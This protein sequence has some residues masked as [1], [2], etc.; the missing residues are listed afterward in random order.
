MNPLTSQRGIL[1]VLL[2]TVWLLNACSVVPHRESLPGNAINPEKITHWQIIGKIA[3]RSPERNSS[4]RLRWKQQDG[5]FNIGLSGPLGR[6]VMNISGTQQEALIEITGQES[7]Y[8]TEPEQTLREQTG[9]DIPLNALL[10]W[11]RGGP[12][13]NQASH[14]QLDAVGRNINM[15]QAGW[16]LEYSKYRAVNGFW[17]PGKIS[18]RK[19][20]KLLLLVINQWILPNNSAQFR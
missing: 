16:N 10:Y 17:L 19:Q 15:K 2:A 1:L 14:Y 4:G 12:A 20:D 7:Y 5:Q 18:I 13:P 8:T 3:Y 6:G 9:T 11:I